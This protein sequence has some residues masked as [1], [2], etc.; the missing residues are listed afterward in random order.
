MRERQ[1][2]ERLS[3]FIGSQPGIIAVAEHGVEVYSSDTHTLNKCR[4]KIRRG[5]IIV[6]VTSS[7]L[8]SCTD[9]AT[10]LVS[11]PNPNS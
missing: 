5:S 6:K 2:L 4:M 7:F 11:K 10:N 9:K 1:N 3:D 8:S